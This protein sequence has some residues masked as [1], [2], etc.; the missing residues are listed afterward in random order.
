[1]SYLMGT[2]RA[3]V[4]RLLDVVDRG[5]RIRKIR[6]F[7]KNSWLRQVENIVHVGA[8]AGQ[9]V[10]LYHV[11]KLGVLWI[12]P[13]PSVFAELEKNITP[14]PR[15]RACQ[16]LVADVPNKTYSFNIASNGGQS[17][18]IFDLGEHKELWPEIVYT[19]RIDI[20][21]R[22]LAD[23]LVKEPLKYD[24]LVMD[25]Q[26]AELL[27]LKGAADLLS[28]FKFIKAEAA[29]FEL[30]KGAATTNELVKFLSGFDLVRRD[31]YARNCKGEA[32]N[33]L[34]RR[35]ES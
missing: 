2:V 3:A 28:Q 17:S 23:I 29:D 8:N 12:E 7:Y 31:A 14:Y 35:Q 13:I 20:V 21:S 5:N 4:G 33:L 9:E 15:Q 18:S 26:G 16:A 19:E 6:D 11:Y 34:F 10:W 1:M 32:V 30:Y 27:V 24:G 25:V 22:T